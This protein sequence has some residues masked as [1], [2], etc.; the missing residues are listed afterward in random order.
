[1][2]KVPSFRPNPDLKL[3]D[4]LRDV[5]RYYHYAYCTEKSTATGSVKACQD[6]IIC[7]HIPATT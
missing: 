7:R 5:L 1:M 4:Q 6:S 3:M 2:E